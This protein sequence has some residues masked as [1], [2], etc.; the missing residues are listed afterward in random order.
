MTGNAWRGKL[1]V[2]DSVAM[3]SPQL[4]DHFERPRNSGELPD[5]DA[6]VRIENPACGDILELAIRMDAGRIG[7]IRFRAKGCVPAMAC[8]SAMTELAKGRSRQEARAIGKADIVDAVG[9]VPPA[10]GHAAQLAIDALT[11]ALQKLG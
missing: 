10:S 9:G 3:Y 2:A 6:Q 11:A 5:A 4:L 1:L 8:A 7:E